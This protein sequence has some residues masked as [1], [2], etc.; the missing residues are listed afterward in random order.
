MKKFNFKP[1]ETDKNSAQIFM[2]LQINYK[3]VEKILEL[4]KSRIVKIYDYHLDNVRSNLPKS[5]NYVDFTELYTIGKK[6]YA[7]INNDNEFSTSQKSVW[8]KT[9]SKLGLKNDFFIKFFPNSKQYHQNQISNI[10]KFKLI[11]PYGEDD[12]Y[13]T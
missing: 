3:D 2:C 1:A 6:K 10:V 12:F 7:I 11:N 4:L 9:H 8:L 5:T 13:W